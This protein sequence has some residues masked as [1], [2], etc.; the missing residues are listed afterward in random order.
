MLGGERLAG[1]LAGVGVDPAGDV[2]GHQQARAGHRP[3]DRRGRRGAEPAAPADAGDAVEHQ[4]GPVQPGGAG[5]VDAAAGPPQPGQPGRVRPVGVQQ[6]RGD[7]GAPAGQVRAGPQRVAA[8]V[9]RPHQQHHAQADGPA[10]QPQAHGGQPGG[11]PL[12]ERALGAGASTGASAAR[13]WSAVYSP[14]TS[15]LRDHH[16]RGDAPVV[17]QRHVPAG[18]PQLRGPRATVP[19]TTSSG[20]PWS[21]TVTSASCQCRSPGAPSA[22]ASASLAANRAASDSPVRG[23]PTG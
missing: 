17:A 9:A 14:V 16:G 11:R 10:G 23:A 1:H 22:L 20:R 19:R 5:S 13:T 6:Q 3:G 7:R 2:D 15:P 18:H 4:V 21:P 12:H 8:V